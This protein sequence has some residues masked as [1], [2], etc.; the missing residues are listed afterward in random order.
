MKVISFVIPVFNSEKTISQVVREIIIIC[1]QKNIKFEIVLVN[2]CSTDN[3]FKKCK[4]LAT[5]NRFIKVINLSK[6]YGQHNALITGFRFINGDYIICLDD[7]LQTP[8]RESIK[9][10]KSITSESYD[11]VYADY[12]KKMQNGWRNFGS[13][14]NNL[15]ANLLLGKPHNLNITS[16]FIMKCFIVKEIVKYEGYCVYI[17][18][19]IL[20][21]TTNIGNIEVEHRERKFGKSN[22]TL[23]KLLS[24]WMNGFINFS[25]KPL[26]LCTFSGFAISILGFFFALVILI[27]RIINPNIPVGW[28]SL[29]LLI[30]VLSGLNLIFVGLIGEYIGKVLLNISKQP[31]SVIKE[32][33][34]V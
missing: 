13:A 3:S 11:V 19:L 7:D 5:K 17:P 28:T 22:Y 34:N 30:I 16:F 14:I 2:D 31:Q 20:Q 27:K 26:R 23:I 32:S 24:L 33:I 4:E 10:I 25:V 1:R 8:P 6:N 29:I 12:P 18:G 9:L 21:I 15:M